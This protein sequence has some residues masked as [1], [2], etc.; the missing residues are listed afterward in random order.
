[1]SK[2]F[3]GSLCLTDILEAAKNGHS[4]FSKSA[5]ND[6]VYFNV[7]TWQNDQ[8]D[9]YG[10]IMSHQLNSRKEMRESEPA[11]YIGNSKQMESSKPISNNDLDDS[12][13]SNIPVA[14]RE[15]AQT[16][17]ESVEPADDLPF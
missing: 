13:L 8:P 16:V 5:K 11:F 3:A 2:L 15:E 7:A 10:N 14:A 1:M 17:P 12:A 9:K 4:A 6:K